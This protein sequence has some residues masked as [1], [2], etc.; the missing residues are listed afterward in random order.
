MQNTCANAVEII[1]DHL[2]LL[3]VINPNVIINSESNSILYI[4]K[5][6]QFC[7]AL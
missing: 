7:K 3:S 1:R 2:T 5:M 6:Y 4:A